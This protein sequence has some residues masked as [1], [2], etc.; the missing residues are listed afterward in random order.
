MVNIDDAAEEREILS[1]PEAPIVRDA[2]LFNHYTM[3]TITTF[4]AGE[5]GVYYL[6]V[7][8]LFQH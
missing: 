3:K 2:K 1:Y 8:H 6:N 7:R 5:N 4:A